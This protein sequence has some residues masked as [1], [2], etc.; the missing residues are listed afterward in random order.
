VSALITNPYKQIVR[1]QSRQAQTDEN[2]SRYARFE[3]KLVTT[4]SQKSQFPNPI[5]FDCTFVQEPH[6]VTGIYCAGDDL[7]GAAVFP[8]VTVGISRFISSPQGYYTGAYVWFN[9]DVGIFD[10]FEIHH[11]FTFSGTAIKGLPAHLL[12]K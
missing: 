5:T 7:D 1:G 2:A 10:D 3:C 12:D 6:V 4:G 9:I 11:Y 8:A